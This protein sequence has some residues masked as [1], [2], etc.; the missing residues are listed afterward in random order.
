MKVEVVDD[1]AV[2]TGCM[3]LGE[4]DFEVALGHQ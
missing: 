4:V 3:V 2:G 1:V